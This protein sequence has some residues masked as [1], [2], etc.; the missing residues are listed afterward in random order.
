MVPVVTATGRV[1]VV[2]D[3]PT[4]REVVVRYLEREGLIVD[5]VGDGEAAIE[6][7]NANWP[8]LVVLDLMLPRLD[9][10]DVCRILRARA[11]CR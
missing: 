2:E 9:G 11:P 4:V 6:H 3:D 7:A 5:A 10:I 1:L 8:D